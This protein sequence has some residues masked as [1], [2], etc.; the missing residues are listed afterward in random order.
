MQTKPLKAASA[1]LAAALLSGCVMHSHHAPMAGANSAH[2][3][4]EAAIGSNFEI[5]SSRLAL[6]KSRDSEV[7]SFAK[8]MIKDHTAASA[9]LRNAVAHSNVSQDEIVKTLDEEHQAKLNELKRLS[10]HDFDV[11][12]IEDQRAAH[13]EAVRLFRNYRASGRSESLHY[14]A[15]STLPTLEMHEQKVYNLVP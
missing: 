4:H 8:M 6:R 13:S 12:Y 11:A 14:F 15:A 10:G 9:D 2:F 1:M 5:M 3:V 7:R